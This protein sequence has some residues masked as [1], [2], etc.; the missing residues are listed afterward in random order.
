MSIR[1][2]PGTQK[3][4]WLIEQKEFKDHWLHRCWTTNKWSPPGSYWK[5]GPTWAA[6][7]SLWLEKQGKNLGLLKPRSS[8]TGSANLGI[9]LWREY[10]PDGSRTSQKAL[11]GCFGKIWKNLEGCTKHKSEVSAHTKATLTRKG[12]KTG[13][14]RIHFPPLVSYLW[15]SV[16][17]QMRRDQLGL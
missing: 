4:Q 6:C 10:H 17:S 9:I 15:I 16:D 5:A 12:R 3:P 1:I 11:W 7:P 2:Q 8:L 14:F 13:R